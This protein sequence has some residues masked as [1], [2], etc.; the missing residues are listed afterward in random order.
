MFGYNMRLALMSFRRNPG[1]SALMVVAIALGIAVCI[2]TL[3]VYHAMSGN[4]IWWKNDRLYAVTMDNW[5][6][7]QAY[8]R[9]GSVMPPPQM[10]Y[11]DATHLLTSKIPERKTAMYVVDGVISGAGAAAARIETR[12]ATADFFAMFDVPFLYGSGW[13]GTADSPPQPVIVLSRTQNEKLFGGANSVG[14]TLRWNDHEFR[15]VGVLDDWQPQPRFYDLNGGNFQ[16]P[17]DAYIPFAWGKELELLSSGNTDCWR[18]QKLDTVA[19]FF[20]FRLHLDPDVGRAAGRAGARTHAGLHRRLLG[21]AAQGGPVRA[22]TRQPPDQRWPVAARPQGGRQ[23]QPRAGGPGVCLPRRVSYQHRGP[24]AGEIPQ[25][26]RGHRRTAGLGCQ[27]PADL[28]AAPG[29]G[30]HAL[31]TGRHSRARACARSDLPPSTTCMRP[32][33]WVAPAVTRNS[34]TWILRGCC[35]RWHWP[36][37]PRWRRDCIR[38]GASVVCHPPCI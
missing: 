24:A 16:A 3:T 28:R 38:P 22:P 6:P 8:N 13:S 37:P 19:E 36:S 34:P 23:R 29:R 4:P 18:P 25:R 1:L 14:R 33:T 9:D 15:V 35:G 31:G 26:R 32:R 30:R 11:P 7:N 5:D 17:E 20:E 10:T 12:L 2:M 21:R 27:P